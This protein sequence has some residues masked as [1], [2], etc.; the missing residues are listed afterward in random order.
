MRY[1]LKKSKAW[2][3]QVSKHVIMNFYDF[4]TNVN[5]HDVT[6]QNSSNCKKQLALGINLEKDLEMLQPDFPSHVNIAYRSYLKHHK[7]QY[8]GNEHDL[9]KHIFSENWRKIVEHNS[10]NLSYKME[11]NKFSDRT[12]EELEHLTG[13]RPSRS[14]NVGTHRFPYTL[15][16]VE[17]IVEELPKEFDLRLEGFI[18]PIK[19]QGNCGSCWAFST[20]AAVEGAVAKSNGGI[21]VDLSEQSLVDCAWGYQNYGCDGGMLDSAFQYIVDKGIP[22]DAD[23]GIYMEQDG[24][25]NLLNISDT[26]K[27]AGFAQVTPR[28]PNSMKVALYKYGPVAVAIHAN[29]N[30]KQYSNG[31]YYDPECKGESLNHG[32]TVVGYGIRDGEDYWIVRN[33]WGADW[34]EDGYILMSAAGDN[35]LILD[36]PYYAIV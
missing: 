7:K 9:R 15:E 34:G 21:R 31:I 2:K 14:K 11:I 1:E 3:G 6:P 17:N 18:R 8:T 35:C 19:S 25:C 26:Y 16:E 10:K 36:S 4:N 22:T 23:Y 29:T 32:V 13:T 12:E 33:S 28:S 5:L 20:T 27:I 30:M 24:Y